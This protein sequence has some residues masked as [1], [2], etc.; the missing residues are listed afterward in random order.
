ML[1]DELVAAIEADPDDVE[2][3]RV[4]AD[5]LERA[6]DPRGQLITMQ[7]LLETLRDAVKR[8]HLQN[9]IVQYIDRHRAAFV[10]R[11]TASLPTATLLQYWRFGFQRVVYAH[12]AAAMQAVLE[13]VLAHPSCRFVTEVQLL[14]HGKHGQPVIDVVAR[15]APATLRELEL[16]VGANDLSALWPRCAR[17]RRLL[18]MG[19]GL[20]LGDVVLPALE[21]LHVVG[22]RR[23][24]RALLAPPYPRLRRVDIQSQ[25]LSPI[26][27]APLLARTQRLDRL[28]ITGVALDRR[29]RAM[30]RKLADDVK[31]R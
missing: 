19:T 2:N 31:L 10:P 6:G 20:E 1:A 3:Y 12:E 9:R 29:E 4:Y 25:D 17:L 27:L 14:L 30:L 22:E 24:V 26:D 18:V 7:L 16:R 21:E 13:E 28:H 11:M 8:E 23:A 5:V 15:R